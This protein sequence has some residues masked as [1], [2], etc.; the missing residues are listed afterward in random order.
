M[1]QG[2]L[3]QV[4]SD[5]SSLTSTVGN[6]QT[7]I[8]AI[9]T[10]VDALPEPIEPNDYS[11]ELADLASGL[12]DAQTTID[13]LNAALANVATTADLGTISSTLAEVQADVRELLESNAVINQ[14]ITINNDATLLYAETLVGTATDDPNVI[15]NGYVSVTVNTTN[16][17]AAELARVNAITAKLATVLQYVTISNTSSPSVAVDLPNLT[18][19]DG[20]YSVSGADAND[21][22]LRTVSGDLLISHGGAAD[23]S[24]ITTVGGNVSIDPSVT[25]I[26]LSGASI[27]GNVSSNGTA[28]VIVLPK[29]TSV[30]IGTAQVNTA[31]LTLAEGA[32]N[33]GYA[34][35]ISGNVLIEAPKAG[36]IDFAAGTVTGTL[37]VSSKADATIFNAANLTTASAT[38]ISAEEAN[39][40]KL[41]MF[42]GNSAITADT[43]TFPALTGNASGTLD[44]PN[45]DSFV[46]PKFVISSTV[47]ATDA[48][49]V[50]F[51]SGSHANLSA[52]KAK[53]L[54][55]NE[56]GNTTNFDTTG[57]AGTLETF[58]ITGKVNSSPTAAN[59]TS[60]V[61]ITGAKIKTASIN[62]MIDS[63]IVTGVGALTSLTTAG[64]MRILQVDNAA[65]LTSVG[66]GH[67]HINGSG[68]A[69]LHFTNNAKLASVNLSSVSDVGIIQIENNA[70]LAAITAPATSPLIE[71][72]ATVV[73]TV[74]NNKLQ[75]TYTAAKAAIAG[76]ITTP[77]V[78]AVPSS[79][80]QASVYGLR[81][82]L[83]AHY[84][85]VA[86]PTYNI[87][88]DA[89]DSDDDG[90][91]DDGD[92]VTVAGADANNTTNDG[93]KQIDVVAELATVKN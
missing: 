36:T 63:T 93:I 2:R 1:K 51:S 86:S 92:Y 28:G 7:A 73:A 46:A 83:E 11:T 3:T 61:T 84:S 49:T 57:Y 15:V 39:F 8:T 5:L 17:D 82:W 76:T 47:S 25:S 88:I 75:G 33:L 22:A 21:D 59:V 19:V 4:Q 65:V 23:Y 50:E 79:I 70:E 32:V 66:L 44:L 13:A 6:L 60:V 12:T 10:S 87:E 77:A 27:M 89:L 18:F 68:A 29:A 9:Q 55:I 14:N 58:N 91:F 69:Q 38:T 85:H 26:N 54:T 40:P 64:S 71:T 37:T 45:A 16:F 78:A 34:G 20:N 35:T 56:Q 72:V 48:I 90:A 80:S 31:S 67:D 42:T 43:V 24:Q 53:T 41:T 81:L 74:T 62:G 30:N 52:P